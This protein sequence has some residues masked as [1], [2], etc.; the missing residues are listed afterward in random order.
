MS[1]GP[2]TQ[3]GPQAHANNHKVLMWCSYLASGGQEVTQAAVYLLQLG[4]QA[5]QLALAALRGKVLGD[6]EE[7]QAGGYYGAG[8][9]SSQVP[10]HL[11]KPTAPKPPKQVGASR[12]SPTLTTLV[13]FFP[14]SL[15]R[16]CM[17]WMCW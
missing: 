17:N 11:S 14:R 13:L 9:R 6:G 1:L 8:S 15:W 10:G 7:E 3:D 2:I 4:D 5:P 12:T 16:S